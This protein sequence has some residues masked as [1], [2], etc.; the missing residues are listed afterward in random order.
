MIDHFTRPQFEAAL[1]VHNKTGARLWGY[2]GFLTTAPR[3][4]PNCPNILP[5]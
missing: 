4:V 2:C 1:P 3:W 5:G